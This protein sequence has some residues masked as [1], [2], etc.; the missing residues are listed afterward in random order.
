MDTTLIK[1]AIGVLLFILI[2]SNN[3]ELFQ[4]TSIF[5]FVAVVIHTFL[6]KYARKNKF[7]LA[8]IYLMIMIFQLVYNSTVIFS[9]NNNIFTSIASKIIGSIMILL[10]VFIDRMAS[11][12]HGIKSYMPSIQD[13]T[14]FT[15]NEIIENVANIKKMV[16]KGQKN[17]SKENIDELLKDLPRHSSFRYINKGSLTSEYFE[18]AYQTL[19]DLHIYIVVSNTGSPASEIISMFTRKQY[20]HASLSFD[21]ELKTIV[22][23]NGGER[24]YPPGLNMEMIN[25]FNKKQDSSIMIYS[26]PTSLEKKK[27]IIDKIKEINEQGNAYNILGLVF[28]LSF[29]KNIM[30]C[31]QFIYKMLKLVDLTYF[32]KQD[33]QIKPTDLVEMDYE[34][35]LNYEYKIQFNKN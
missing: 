33:G 31:S 27:I 23:Y 25:Y 28:K 16:E 18:S 15:F 12:H 26:L 24:I 6:S 13:M 34:R 30:F 7:F 5:I 19:N 11:E 14:V 29:K 22:S 9:E 1:I 10:P 8:S 35:K 20:N 17:L 4:L 3:I 32:E 21:R 2:S